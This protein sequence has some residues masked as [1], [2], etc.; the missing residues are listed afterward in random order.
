MIGDVGAGIFFGI[1]GG[2]L[3]LFFVAAWE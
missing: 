2:L 1:I 3:F